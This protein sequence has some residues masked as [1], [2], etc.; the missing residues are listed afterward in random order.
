MTTDDSRRYESKA[1]VDFK[2]EKFSKISKN[3]LCLMAHYSSEGIVHDYLLFYIN[4]LK[5]NGFDVLLASSSG[6]VE[7]EKEK[8]KDLTI[9]LLTQE[10]Y[11]WDFGLWKTTLYLLEGEIKLESKVDTILIANDSVYGPLYDLKKIF[12]KMDNL[13]IDFWGMNESLEGRK[14]FQSYFIVF[15]KKIID[16]DFFWNFW[17]DLKYYYD[18]RTVIEN[19]EMNLSDLFFQKGFSGAA[20]LSSEALPKVISSLPNRANLSMHEMNPTLHLWEP[21]IRSF[22]FPFVKGEL[23]R[24]KMLSKE[25]E[26]N[27]RELVESTG[28][29]LDI[30]ESHLRSKR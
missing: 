9:G 24:K 30:M 3:K 26:A 8:I 10:N 20:Y 11:G 19:Y 25:K 29:P 17:K 1:K 12:S 23:L 13:K 7:S 18:K 27:L 2:F 28:Y 21:L 5:K 14:H 4:A 15:Q 6:V 16:S 22:E